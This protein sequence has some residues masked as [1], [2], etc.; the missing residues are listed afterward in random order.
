MELFAGTVGENIARLG[1]VDS[2]RVVE[3]AQLAHAHAMILRL[4]QGY[5]TPIGDGGAALSGGQRQRIALARALYGSPR[6]V[7]LDEPN[8][9]LDS[10]G[11][12]ALAAALAALKARGTT[13]VLVGHRPALMAR[14]DKL[15]L[16]REGALE[17]FG[18]AA[19]VLARLR[20][21]RSVTS[22]RLPAESA[23]E[24]EIRA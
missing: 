11:E 2:A 4:P 18:P 7:V 3:A 16:L 14:L 1:A 24:Q 8:A 21:L 15:A 23:S 9:N 19:A 5:D 20:P 12:A 10:E 6:L 22:T 17:A 13:V